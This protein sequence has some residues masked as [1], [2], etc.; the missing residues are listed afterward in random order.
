MNKP[1]QHPASTARSAALDAQAAPDADLRGSL[2]HALQDQAGRTPHA[3]HSALQDRVMAQWQQRHPQAELALAGAAHS[4]WRL[5][6]VHRG[7][8][9]VA[10]ALAVVVALTVWVNR[11]DPVLEELMQLDVLSQIALGEM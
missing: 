10:L 6:A 9:V 8:V 4:G 5:G 7:W 2:R 3:E 1:V 11:P